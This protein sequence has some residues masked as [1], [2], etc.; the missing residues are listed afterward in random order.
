MNGMQQVITVKEARQITGGR[1]PLV[2]VVYEDACKALAACIDL[3]DA[4]YWSDKAD[5]LAAWAKIYH[6][7][8]LSLDAKRLKLKAYR[9]MGQI[10]EELRPTI[11]VGKR[12][13]GAQS[14]LRESGLSEAQAA[15]ARGLSVANEKHF[16]ELVNRKIPPSP[17]SARN[18][19]RTSGSD[20]WRDFRKLGGSFQF[21]TY[22]RQFSARALAKS[23]R[24][25]EAAK[26][27]VIIVELQEWLDEFEQH[28]PK[29]K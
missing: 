29:A 2:P 14:L 21:R 5:A 22:C 25:D 1:T 23:L 27:L 6:D 4:K 9:R 26:A 19:V 11:T 13:K 24:P 16:A 7:D 8:T 10:A 12:G 20:G 17:M 3:D 15:A 28:L 18:Y